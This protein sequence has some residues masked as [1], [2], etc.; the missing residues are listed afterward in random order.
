MRTTTSW[1]ASGA[2]G[3]LMTVAGSACV[4]TQGLPREPGNENP[5]DPGRVQPAEEEISITRCVRWRD[6]TLLP[7]G[8]I[9]VRGEIESDPEAAASPDPLDVTV[10]LSRF[11]GRPQPLDAHQ[12]ATTV[13]SQARTRD[14]AF[15]VEF[16]VRDVR[17]S[18]LRIQHFRV[19]A[20][21]RRP[22]SLAGMPRKRPSTVPVENSDWLAIR[23]PTPPLD[24]ML[25]ALPSL[26]PYRYDPVAM[27]RIC[28]ALRALGKDRALDALENYTRRAPRKTRSLI[29][30]AIAGG[31]ADDLAPLDALPLLIRVLFEPG[32]EA[33]PLPPVIDV[34]LIRESHIQAAS[35]LDLFPMVVR[36]GVP[37][38]LPAFSGGGS[39]QY[40]SPLLHLDWARWHGQPLAED[41]TPTD[42]I[43][44]VA[45][46]LHASLQAAGAFEGEPPMFDP[47]WQAWR[48]VADVLSLPCPPWEVRRTRELPLPDWQELKQRASER[49]LRWNGESGLYETTR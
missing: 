44:G 4:T 8:R 45:E 16:D 40:P 24:E 12:L 36:E 30:H 6:M 19:G 13:T 48:A 42:D 3:L 31:A 27:V 21:L 25:E 1:L 2:G 15:E 14:G 26:D 23:G 5:P 43:L 29:E 33:N 20:I 10:V 7:A 17:V 49:R 41:L 18:P 22:P 9:R 11:A 34:L 37:F 39:G 47:R 38:Y 46:R 32:A 35:D 28:N